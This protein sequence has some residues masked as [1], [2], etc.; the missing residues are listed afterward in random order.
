[1]HTS[2]P[3]P[4]TQAFEHFASLATRYTGSA[5]AFALALSIILVWVASGPFFKFSDTWQLVINTGTTVVTFL[6]VFVIQKSQNKDSKAIQMKLDELIAVHK[7]AS[8]RLIAIED[9]TE[10]EL[11]VLHRYYQ[12]L[13]EQAKRERTLYH[14][15]SITNADAN[16]A[17]KVDESREPSMHP[18]EQHGS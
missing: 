17:L 16:H 15:H 3:K 6:M 14:T 8:N 12:R 2:K 7:R 9:L 4:V 10:D 11:N 1:M 5:A 13:A 18:D